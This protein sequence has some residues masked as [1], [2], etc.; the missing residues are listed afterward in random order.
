LIVTG[1]IVATMTIDHFGL[2]RAPA[3]PLTAVRVVGAG[4]MAIGVFL[5][6]RR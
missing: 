3:F 2:L 5:A 1:Q 4:L 6:V